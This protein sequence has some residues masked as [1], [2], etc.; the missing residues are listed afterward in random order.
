M[1]ENILKD[2]ILSHLGTTKLSGKGFRTRNCMMC[3]TLGESADTRGRFGIRFD[4][5]MIVI[6]CFNCGFEALWKPGEPLQQNMRGFLKEIGVPNRDIQQLVFIAYREKHEVVTD[7]N[8]I[9]GSVTSKWKPMALPDG[10]LPITEWHGY[11]CDERDFLK[12]YNYAVDRKLGNLSELYWSPD[13]KF[14]MNK[15]LILPFKYDSEVVGYTGRY[16][17]EPPSKKIPKYLNQMPDS[18]IFNL[19]NQKHADREFVIMPEGVLD[20]RTV[21]GISP[22]NNTLSDEQIDIINHLGKQVIVVPDK[23][24]GGDEF[25]NVA[26]KQKWAVAF[27]K[28]NRGI[29]DCAKAS[30]VYGRILTLQSIIESAV[31]DPIKI[32]LQWRL[33]ASERN[34]GL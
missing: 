33:T 14:S 9:E 3:H 6:N 16:Y 17:C 26:I 8:T 25:V 4:G 12:V 34:K 1:I 30:E 22:I 24:K 11:G 10:S 21:D 18:F 13:K 27:P 19:D 7:T 5:G 20:S 31:K 29:K 2:T 32:R 28:W 23:D 15:R